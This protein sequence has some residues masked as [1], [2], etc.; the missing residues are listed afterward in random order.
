MIGALESKM[1]RLLISLGRLSNINARIWPARFR[2]AT[3][4]KRVIDNTQLQ[5][6]YLVSLS[7]KEETANKKKILSSKILSAIGDFETSIKGS[8][9]FESTAS[10]V[11]L[12]MDLT[13]KKKVL[14][15]GLVLDQRDW[16]EDS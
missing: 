12:S 15:M 13:P 1:T 11:L 14:E 6:C 16:S 8:K 3:T 10:N 9:E 7:A 5:G 4:D 2:F